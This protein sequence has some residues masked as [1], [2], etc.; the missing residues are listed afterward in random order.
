V[1]TN[2]FSRFLTGAACLGALTLLTGCFETKD[3]FTLN[4]DGSG[5]VI[6]ECSF[7]KVSLG[8]DDEITE[9]ALKEAIG[10]VLTEAKGVEAWRDVS[11]KRLDDGRLYF[12]GTA[13]FTNLNTLDIPNQ[14]MLEFAWQKTTGG[15]VLTLRTN[16]SDRAD[17]VSGDTKPVDLTKLTPAERAQK[18]KEERA[19]FQQAKA[20]MNA[21]MGSMKHDAVFRLPGSV[22]ESSNFSREPG[23]AVRVQFEGAK[24]M[25]AMESL[26]NNDEWAAQNLESLG[27]QA[28]PR[29]DDELNGLVFSTNGPV[30]VTVRGGQPLFNYATEVA[31]AKVETEKIRKQL[32]LGST[33]VVVAAPAQGGGLQ[34]AKVVGVRLVSDLSAK[35]KEFRPFNQD[36]GYTLAVQVDFP[37]SILGLTDESKFTAA[38]ADD[39]SS[40][41]E[42]SDWKRK[43]NWP[44]LSSDRTSALIEVELKLPAPGV[45]V[46]G[47]KELSAQLQYQVASATKQVD[48]GFTEIKANAKGSEFGA[49][50][51]GIKEGWNKDGSQQLDLRLNLSRESLKAVRLVANGTTTELERRGYSGGGNSYTFTYESKIAFPAQGKLVAEV[52]DQLQTFETSFKLENISLFGVPVSGK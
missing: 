11:Y 19:K 15:A 28:K 52:Y 30:R 36:A 46:K 41:L 33:T 2:S 48:L 17:G 9:D 29:M 18:L 38:V 26:I 7:Q 5:K 49:Q 25:S 24:L 12:K 21:F 8:G 40:L 31:A 10:K 6:H 35:D 34:G 1:K 16:K 13:Y 47:L 22:T 43:I 27:G 14:T 32:N 50:I 39:G 3:E 44:K 20:M 23:G 4:P 51:R 42:A 37:G 45:S